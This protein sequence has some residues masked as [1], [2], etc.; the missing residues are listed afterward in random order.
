MIAVSPAGWG[1]DMM[2]LERP[3]HDG[4]LEVQRRLGEVAEGERNGRVVADT[5]L[6]GALKF[7][8]QQQMAVLSSESADGT[9]WASVLFGEQGFAVAADDQTVVFD[10]ARAGIDEADPFWENI[11]TSDRMGALFIELST[12]RRLRINGRVE[13]TSDDRLV[14]KVSESYPNCPKY[15]QRREIR[16]EKGQPVATV[17]AVR[18]RGERLDAE[19]ADWIA[20]ADTFF[21]GSGHVDRGLDASH[22]GGPPG[23]VEV[24]DDRTLRVPDYVGNSMYNTLGNLMT[25]PRASLVFVDFERGRVLQ[26][27]GEAEVIW[28]GDDPANRTGGTKRFWKFHVSRWRASALPGAVQTEFM[29]HSPFNPKS[30]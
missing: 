1:G 15:I 29:D 25:N 5:I 7:I 2:R 3:Y 12:R 27:V 22:R 10:L 13:R 11:A 20:G 26:L 21:V 14:L 18:T 4:E 9:I 23:F 16:F 30:Q 6:K 19:L 8:G 17:D 24:V 28:D